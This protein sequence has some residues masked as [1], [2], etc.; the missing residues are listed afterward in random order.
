MWGF[1]IGKKGRIFSLRHFL[2]FI[3][4]G[5]T[6]GGGDQRLAAIS[7]SERD[8][9]IQVLKKTSYSNLKVQFF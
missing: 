6:S 1:T 8:A 4:T 3:S 9:W 2:S 5:L 7:E